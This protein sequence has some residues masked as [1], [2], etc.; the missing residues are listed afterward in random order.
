MWF[1][2]IVIVSYIWC[3]GLLGLDFHVY[4]WG[5]SP[6][7]Q[8][9]YTLMMPYHMKRPM[10]ANLC[11]SLNNN[12]SRTNRLR[13]SP[14]PPAPSAAAPVLTKM[15]G[16]PRSYTIDACLSRLFGR[17]GGPAS[18]LLYLFAVLRWLK[19]CYRLHYT[20]HRLKYSCQEGGVRQLRH[21]TRWNIGTYNRDSRLP[22]FYRIK[23]RNHKVFVMSVCAH[24]SRD[25]LV[26]SAHQMRPRANNRPPLTLWR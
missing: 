13:R 14:S 20:Q 10:A 18:I 2:S 6:T 25:E 1:R 19:A 17:E 7:P 26:H 9:L 15:K 3:L 21:T 12:T 11:S 8:T 22:S 23:K 4:A 16:L 5:N 24:L